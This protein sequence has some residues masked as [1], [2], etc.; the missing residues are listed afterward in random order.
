M[1][2]VSVFF[3][4]FSAFSIAQINNIVQGPFK[5]GEGRSIYS[6]KESNENY[7]LGLYF[8]VNGQSCKVDA[9]ET[10]GSSPNIDAVF[11]L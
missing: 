4:F 7:P 6:K 9:Y 10:D 5:T 1:K 2:K 11:F 8:D 3:L